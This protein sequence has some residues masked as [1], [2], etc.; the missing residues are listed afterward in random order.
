PER[1]FVTRSAGQ[2]Y[3]ETRPIQE[4]HLPASPGR[5]ALDLAQP[6]VFNRPLVADQT[7]N[8][9]AAVHPGDQRNLI[10]LVNATD[11][12]VNAAQWLEPE[13]P[14]SSLTDRTADFDQVRVD[15]SAWQRVNGV[16]WPFEITHWL[17]GKVDFLIEVA[18]VQMNQSP[19][20]SLFQHP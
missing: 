14:A 19:A 8:S 2:Q 9:L 7:G 12:I 15:F 1:L 11:N 4:D 18:Q 3:A 10:Y 16:L 5:P 17:G 6:I 20:G 13:N